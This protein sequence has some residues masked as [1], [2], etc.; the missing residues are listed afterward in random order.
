MPN[1]YESLFVMKI[2]MTGLLKKV[3]RQVATL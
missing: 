2:M 1:G 3:Q